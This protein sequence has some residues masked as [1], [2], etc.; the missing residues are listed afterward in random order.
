MSLH[1]DSVLFVFMSEKKDLSSDVLRE[2]VQTP[3]PPNLGGSYTG[4]QTPIPLT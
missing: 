2:D 3:T 1:T 4:V